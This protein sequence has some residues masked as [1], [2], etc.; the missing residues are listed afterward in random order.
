MKSRIVAMTVFSAHK[1]DVRKS[2]VSPCK[3]LRREAMG[4]SGTLFLSIPRMKG[5]NGGV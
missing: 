1:L 3:E 5:H 2:V 4:K